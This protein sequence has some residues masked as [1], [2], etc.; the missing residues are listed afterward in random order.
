MSMKK[1]KKETRN[2]KPTKKPNNKYHIKKK[3]KRNTK[4]TKKQNNKFHLKK[5]EKETQNQQKKKT[6]N[7]YHLKNKKET[8]KQKQNTKQKANILLLLFLK[9]FMELFWSLLF[10]FFRFICYLLFSYNHLF[11]WTI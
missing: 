10:V 6:K 8:Q 5:K 11:E 1:N 4:P 9:C 2:T 3:Q 7:K